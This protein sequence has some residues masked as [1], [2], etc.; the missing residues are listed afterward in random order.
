[1]K[2]LLSAVGVSTAVVAGVLA[3]GAGTASAATVSPATGLTC[4]ISPQDSQVGVVCSF[5][6]PT[7]VQYRAWADCTG[8]AVVFGPWEFVNSG[9]VSWATCPRNQFIGDYGWQQT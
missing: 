1:M 9:I 6:G 2:R 4:G 5:P 8:G 7:D 3:F